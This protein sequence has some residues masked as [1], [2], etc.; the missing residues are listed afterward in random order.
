[1]AGSAGGSLAAVVALLAC[2]HPA[3]LGCCRPTTCPAPG[4]CY[5]LTSGYT[6]YRKRSSLWGSAVMAAPHTYTGATHIS[7]RNTPSLALVLPRPGLPWALLLPRLPGGRHN[8]APA[9]MAAT[10]NSRASGSRNCEK[11]DSGKHSAT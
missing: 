8:E 6:T 1:M 10:G 11:V 3:T 7:R 4:H 9:S 5:P 2:L